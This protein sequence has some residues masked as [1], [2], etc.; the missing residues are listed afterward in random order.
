VK[1]LPPSLAA[2]VAAVRARGEA[3]S[4]DLRPAFPRVS[5]P[6]LCNR[7]ATLTELGL[8]VVAR[9]AGRLAYYRA[10]EAAAPAAAPSDLDR[11]AAIYLAL[12]SDAVRVDV[13]IMGGA[14][15]AEGGPP[16]YSASVEGVWPEGG[17]NN[18]E[19]E[20]DDYDAT[21]GAAVARLRALLAAQL[22]ARAA[23]LAAMVRP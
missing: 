18:E 11:I 1:P 2:V 10:V 20:P 3:A 16:R 4:V 5:P 7:L 6:A 15:E 12:H 8:L 19:V 17:G 13:R 21:P 14:P 23:Q 9:R 22:A